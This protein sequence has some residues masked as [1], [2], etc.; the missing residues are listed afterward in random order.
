MKKP[1]VLYRFDEFAVR[2]HWRVVDDI[3]M[4]GHSQGHF[5]ITE[6]KLGRFYGDVSLRDNGG[7]SSV[8]YRFAE[9]YVLPAARTV[10]LHVR[11]DGSAYQFRL[12]S[13][14]SAD[15]VYAFPF[16]TSGAWE[17]IDVPLG[18]MYPVRRGTRL[19][20]PSFSA[21]RI[22]ELGFLIANGRDQDFQL[23]IDRLEV[24]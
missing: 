15:Y 5:A 20:Q 18:A 10:R 8:R 21:D 9:P 7:F 16:P 4:G 19:D 1:I 2:A 6:E 14:V 23:L 11:G 17:A 13:D 3:V 24:L 22:A 12:K